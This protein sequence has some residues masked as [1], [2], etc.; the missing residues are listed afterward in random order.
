MLFRSF[1]LRGKGSLRFIQTHY[2]DRASHDYAK[3]CRAAAGFQL[4]IEKTPCCHDPTGLE[5]NKL[6]T[7]AHAALSNLHWSRNEGLSGHRHHVHHQ[8][9][10][11]SIATTCAI[12]EYRISNFPSDHPLH[13]T[14]ETPEIQPTLLRALKLPSLS[15]HPQ[16]SSAYS[17][18]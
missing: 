7:R 9:A 14:P 8:Y 12:T 4:Y 6:I 1:S 18:A 17:A 13:K 5:R 10:M 3:E 2:D 11:R 15:L 16:L